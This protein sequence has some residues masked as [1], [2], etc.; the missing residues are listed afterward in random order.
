M[1]PVTLTITINNAAQL[2]AILAG[3]GQGAAPA[4]SVELGPIVERNPEPASEGKP[5]RKP[6]P[7]AKPAPEPKPEPAPEPKPEIE[8]AQVG[9]AI[10]GYAAKHG[11]QAALDILARFGVTSGKHLKPEQYADVLEALQGE[12]A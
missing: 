5:E 1:F 3:L 4:P 10:V 8:Y 2:N 11:K 6:E 7:K 9:G 12:P